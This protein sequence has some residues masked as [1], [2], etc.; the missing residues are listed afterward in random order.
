MKKSMLKK[1]VMMTL[2]M[3]ALYVPGLA[4]AEEAAAP[5][6]FALD[7]VV[8]TASMIEQN[9]FD[10]HANMSIVTAEEIEKKHYSDTV[11]IVRNIQGVSVQD[12]GDAGHDSSSNLR[13]NGSKLVIVLVDGVRVSNTNIGNFQAIKSVPVENIERIEVM[14]GAGSALYGADAVGGVVNIITKK[15]DGS[16]TTVGI[17]GGSYKTEEYKVYNQGKQ[18]KFSWRVNAKKNHLGNYNDGH[19]EQHK[20]SLNSDTVGLMIREEFKEGTDLSVSYDRYNGDFL[21]EDTYG[22]SGVV[23]GKNKNENFT[24]SSNQKFDD[25]TTNKITIKKTKYDTKFDS[26]YGWTYSTYGSNE[27]HYKNEV[28]GW[29]FND[30]FTKKIGNHVIVA[31][32]EYNNDKVHYDTGY[33]STDEKI[34]NKAILIQDSWQ[35]NDKWDMTVGVRRDNH[36]IAGNATTPRANFGYKFDEK[37]NMYIGYNKFFV[38]PLFNNYFGKWG[39]RDLKPEKGHT[40]EAGWNHRFDESSEASVHVFSRK[41]NDVIG[42]TTKYINLDKEN[43]KGFDVQFSKSYDDFTLRTGYTY[44]N[45]KVEKNDGISYNEKGFVPKHSINVGIDYSK[46]KFDSTFDLRGALKRGSFEGQFPSENYWVADL[47]MN[48]KAVKN[49]KVFLKINNLFDKYYAEHTYK[50][51]AGAPNQFYG[52]PG[53][54]IIAGMEYSF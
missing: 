13:I 45:S 11:E 18:G 4:S 41:T 52:M 46:G 27:Q 20:R 15:V 34:I 40:W 29:S 28:R 54:T 35:I 42:Y 12:Y 39:N 30:T 37:N 19:D 43:A 7:E 36:N 32:L 10:A 26:I 38:A 1:M 31:G 44:T 51:G 9:K 23:K 48:Y 53:R 5:Q 50:T 3:G 49:G 22:G 2:A 17:S 21:Y 24:I 8:V 25:S 16:K 47:S 14:K 6:E 33:G